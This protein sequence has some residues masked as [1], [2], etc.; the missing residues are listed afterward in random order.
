MSIF[1]TVNKGVLEE[2]AYFVKLVV[3]ELSLHSAWGQQ[4]FNI[5]KHFNLMVTFLVSGL[6]HGANETFVLWGGVHGIYL[7]IEDVF[8]PVS[9]WL[10]QR[11]DTQRFSWKF[12]RAVRTF[13]FVDITWVFF[14]AETVEAAIYIIGKSFDIKNIGLILNKGLFQLGLDERNMTI[15]LMGLSVLIIVSFMKEYGMNVFVW[16]SDQNLVF[17]YLVYWS[18]LVLIIFSV[19]IAGQEFIYFQ[20]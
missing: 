13:I 12:L 11:F 8:L 3:K 6:W 2:M 18:A 17:R 15:L 4:V 20:F 19:D 16:L 14:R 5:K 7:I 10:D 9:K 1:L